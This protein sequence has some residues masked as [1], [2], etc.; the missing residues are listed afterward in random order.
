VKLLL[1]ENAVVS[2][3]HLLWVGRWIEAV[4]CSV[5]GEPGWRFKNGTDAVLWLSADGNEEEGA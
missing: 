2:A 1:R 3:T 4:H 5:M